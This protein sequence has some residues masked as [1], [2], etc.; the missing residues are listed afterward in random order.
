MT[1]VN[2]GKRLLFE[3]YIDAE[4]NDTTHKAIGFCATIATVAGGT[5]S[6]PNNAQTAALSLTTAA[7]KDHNSASLSAAAATFTIPL[8]GLWDF[9]AQ[10]TYPAGGAAG[11]REV[12]IFNSTTSVVLG[13]QTAD[14]AAAVAYTVQAR[15]GPVHCAAGD[16]IQARFFQDSGGALVITAPQFNGQFIGQSGKPGGVSL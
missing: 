14:G 11:R 1:A 13:Q 4:R 5:L 8:A 9:G 3:P 2:P 16:V 6:V 10:C 7:A 12:N 15:T